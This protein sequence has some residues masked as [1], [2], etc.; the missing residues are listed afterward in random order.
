MVLLTLLLPGCTFLF[1]D[2]D[3]EQVDE[4][5]RDGAVD[6]NFFPKELGYVPIYPFFS[7]FSNPVDVIVGYDEMVYV[8]DD[9]GIHVL[10]QA[11]RKAR[12]IP[13]KGATDV[14]QDRM[15]NL[16]V[17]A[18]V[19]VQ[20]GTQT[21][22]VAAVYKLKNTGTAG[23][24]QFVDTIIHPFD[25]ASRALTS[26]RVPDDEK[27][28]FTGVSAYNDNSIKIARTGPVNSLTGIARPDN[29]VLFF[30]K[31]G[32]YTGFSNGLSPEIPNLRSSIGLS[33]IAGFSA[34]PQRVFGLNN[35]RDFIFGQ[36]D[37]T[38]EIEYRVLWIVELNDPDVGTLYVE[39]TALLNFDTSKADGFLY[40]P[41]RFKR[42]SDVFIAPDATGYLFVV[43]AALDSLYQ[44][45][46][47]GFE[48]VNP[49]P[50][51]ESNKQV[52]VSFG[53]RGSGP[54]QFIEPSGV[55]YFRR[56]IYVAD[57]GNGRIC[58]YIL[59]SDLE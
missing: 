31:N 28:R 59:S 48:G 5:F 30:D 49:P 13:L 46:T 9:F 33:S 16:Y 20:V 25:D 24:V 43:D 53:G 26:F 35:S 22:N 52:K 44:F 27:V 34:P 12:V 41:Y 19:D 39:N 1:G 54:F 10:D 4:I 42:P 3:D 6:P 55:C 29:G 36:A 51:F 7:G 23:E 37:T 8:V 58:R 40:Q 11:G 2:K 14:T 45:T 21:F 18:R 17:V 47:A 50:T 32:R 56:M 15:L 57:K 38:L